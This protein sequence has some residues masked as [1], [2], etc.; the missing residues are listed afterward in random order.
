MKAMQIRIQY[1]PKNLSLDQQ[2]GFVLEAIDKIDLTI[3]E[4]Q[5]QIK[6]RDRKNSREK[7]E[8]HSSW[9]EKAK[10]AIEIHRLKRK[11]YKN[12]LNVVTRQIKI[13]G[14]T[15]LDEARLFVAAAH[16]ILDPEIFNKIRN[17]AQNKKNLNFEKA[18]RALPLNLNL[19]R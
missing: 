15:P 8:D 7:K 13:A 17:I 5:T 9:R 16:E 14:S 4:I 2:R 6:V 10:G 11:K 19:K 3:K 12:I 18:E 1:P